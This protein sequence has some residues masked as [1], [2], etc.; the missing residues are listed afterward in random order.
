LGRATQ[1]EASRKASENLVKP[2]NLSKTCQPTHN[3]PNINLPKSEV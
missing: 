2:L 3:K 1:V